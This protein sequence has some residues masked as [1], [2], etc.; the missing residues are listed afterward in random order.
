MSI[1][2]FRYAATF[3][4]FVAGMAC[5]VGIDFGAKFLASLANCF[6]VFLLL[7]MSS[8]SLLHGF[9]W[10]NCSL[11]YFVLTLS[12]ITSLLIFMCYIQMEYLEEDNLSLR[13]LTLLLSYLYTFGVCTRLLASL[14]YLNISILP[15]L[16]SLQ[17]TIPPPLL[18]TVCCIP[19][20]AWLLPPP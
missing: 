7:R 17:P 5:L 12:L 16:H 9:Q 8:Q 4:A 15:T 14:E 20:H 19:V 2:F 10:H 6:E 18:F 1:I 3:A 11:I 13:N